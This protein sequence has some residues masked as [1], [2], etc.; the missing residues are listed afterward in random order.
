M[1]KINTKAIVRNLLLIL[2]KIRFVI[3]Q[4]NFYAWKP[5]SMYA[6]INVL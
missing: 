5:H 1:K 3:R 4:E 2:G 6:L